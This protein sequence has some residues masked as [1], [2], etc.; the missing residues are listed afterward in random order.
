M[1][2]YFFLNA[3]VHGQARHVL[4]PQNTIHVIGQATPPLYFNCSIEFAIPSDAL[5]WTEYITEPV[6]GRT[7]A[8]GVENAPPS[9]SFVESDY[10]VEGNNLI[11]LDANFDDAGTYQCTTAVAS[12]AQRRVEAV[13]LSK[14]VNQRT[15]I[16]LQFVDEVAFDAL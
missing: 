1:C 14:F 8:V 15:E 13:I 7:L 16:T 12:T 11:V 3:G 4:A 10:D 6:H 2:I 9:Q 5:R